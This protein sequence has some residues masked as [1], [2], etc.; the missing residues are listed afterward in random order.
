MPDDA[1]SSSSAAA[2]LQHYHHHQRSYHHDYD[3]GE[4]SSASSGA[5]GIDNNGEGA[6]K[7][8]TQLR[9]RLLAQTR[10]KADFVNDIMLNLDILIY[11]ELCILYYME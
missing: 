4:G 1:T 7:T 5:A 10:R 9:E 11:A 6:Q 3:P 8:Q 2:G